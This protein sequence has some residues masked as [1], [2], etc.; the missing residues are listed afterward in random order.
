MNKQKDNDK[1]LSLSSLTLAKTWTLV[2]RHRLEFNF[3]IYMTLDKNFSICDAQFLHLC[4]KYWP[5]QY[6]FS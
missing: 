1:S 5:T 3:V 6:P 2:V 4:H